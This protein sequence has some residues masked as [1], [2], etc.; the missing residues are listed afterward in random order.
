MASNYINSVEYTKPSRAVVG[1]GG[2]ET[3]ESKEVSEE[4]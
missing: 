1:G 2:S 3:R 4:E